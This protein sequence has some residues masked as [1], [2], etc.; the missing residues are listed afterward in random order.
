MLQTVNIKTFIRSNLAVCFNE[1]WNL[2]QTAACVCSLRSLHP[3]EWR[4]AS[5]QNADQCFDR[6]VKAISNTHRFSAGRWNLQ[7]KKK[8]ITGCQ[9]VYRVLSTWMSIFSQFTG[10]PANASLLWFSL[11]LKDD[12]NICWPAGGAAETTSVRCTHRK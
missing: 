10:I 6:K 1:E 11:Q 5:T 7:Q 2:L 12:W 3:Q 8:K 9:V 4:G